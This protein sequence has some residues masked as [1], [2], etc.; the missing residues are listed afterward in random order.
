M[1]PALSG[2]RSWRWFPLLVSLGVA[3]ILSVIEG[4]MGFI[5]G[6]LTQGLS[7]VAPRLKVV[8]FVSPGQGEAEMLS[9]Q[10]QC[11]ALAGVTT[12]F[13]PAEVVAQELLRN[14][15][16]T[17]A[18]KALGRS[19]FSGTLIVQVD[20]A[21]RAI[22]P[23]LPRRVAEIVRQVQGMKGVQEVHYD[24]LTV[25]A[26]YNLLALQSL[27]RKT[28]WGTRWIL[29]VLVMAGWLVLRMGG[30]GGRSEAQPALWATGLAALFGALVGLTILL[31]WHRGWRAPELLPLSWGW[32][33]SLGW[34]VGMG[35]L[36][37]MILPGGRARREP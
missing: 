33:W 34:G 26:C 1:N 36:T 6:W 4:G 23:P 15:A 10:Q 12:T 2:E 3:G 17:E 19:P 16:L 21:S 18:V 5:Q 11:M 27:V 28:R 31:G 8:A 7:E 37:G 32:G 14:P 9:I 13:K 29:I 24:P 35:T 25:R 30:S 22:T 20:I